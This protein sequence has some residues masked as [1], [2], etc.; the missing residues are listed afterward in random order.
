MANL[1]ISLPEDLKQRMDSLPEFNWSET[2]RLFLAE[3]VSRAL[4]L[5]KLDK[6]LEHSTLSEEDCLKLGERAKEA[7]LRKYRAKGW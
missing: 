6:M 7:M 3:K 2:I 5:Q 1:T 4:L